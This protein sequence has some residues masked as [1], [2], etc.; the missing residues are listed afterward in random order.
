MLSR[1]Q[2]FIEKLF[3]QILLH[4]TLLKTTKRMFFV[5]ENVV[6]QP[7]QCFNLNSCE[8]PFV[9]WVSAN[10]NNFLL[11]SRMYRNGCWCEVLMKHP[12]Q[13]RRL[14][15]TDYLNMAEKWQ[16]RTSEAM[17]LVTW[18]REKLL[19]IQFR[20]NRFADAKSQPVERATNCLKAF[21][22]KTF[23]M[24]RS[25]NFIYHQAKSKNVG[26]HNLKPPATRLMLKGFF[27][28][29][30]TNQV[31]ELAY[32]AARGFLALFNV[33]AVHVEHN[34]KRRCRSFS[35]N[36]FRA[37]RW[38]KLINLSHE[39]FRNRKTV[40]TRFRCGRLSRCLGFVVAGCCDS[41][42]FGFVLDSNE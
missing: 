23:W 7:L 14:S 19:Q 40:S 41:N 32:V 12:S 25:L 9:A 13:K 37:T 6:Q 26:N 22:M 33:I 18:K 1:H 31:V 35:S 15:G 27:A 16:Q 29:T 30:Q 24:V 17:K 4:A 39:K 38:Q 42:R 8:S 36:S 2:F 10:L 21:A 20:S 11:L 34:Y 5:H 28:K 3:R